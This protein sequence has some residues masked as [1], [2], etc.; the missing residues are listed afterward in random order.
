MAPS[1]GLALLGRAC[2]GI[3]TSIL[4]VAAA[5]IMAQW[6]LRREFGTLTGAWTSFANLGG[7]VAAAPLGVLLA[8]I[9]WRA[10]FAA[11]GLAVLGTAVV[12][13]TWLLGDMRFSC[14]AP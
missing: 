7:I 12:P 4:Y 11:M 5:K 2:T 13:N 3:G 14:S 10:S 8:W 6:F 9:G 1:F